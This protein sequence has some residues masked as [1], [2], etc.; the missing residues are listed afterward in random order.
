[1]SLKDEN[2]TQ[3]KKELLRFAL[4]KLFVFAGVCGQVIHAYA[5]LHSDSQLMGRDPRRG[6]MIK[7]GLRRGNPNIA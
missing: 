2:D 7:N 5:F 4:N 1:M 3:T 6:A